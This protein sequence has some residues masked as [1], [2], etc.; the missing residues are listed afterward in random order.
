MTT[1]TAPPPAA[2]PEPA[3]TRV[4]PVTI[5]GMLAVAG[6]FL[7]LGGGAVLAVSGT[8]STLDSGRHA[9]ATPGAA[10]VSDVADIEHTR[11]VESVLGKTTLKASATAEGGKRIFV[12]VGPKA[13]VDRYLAGAPVDTVT[14]LRVDP[15]KLDRTR[16]AGDATPK[17]PARQSFWVAKSS[18]STTAALNWKVRDGSYRLVVMNA[19]GSRRVASDGRLELRLPH[20]STIA[21]ITM[22]AGIG[23]AGGGIAVLVR[24]VGRPR[25]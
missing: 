7:A 22:L 15:F 20:L 24:N 1:V 5:G 17:P 19:D 2:L 3:R 10:L 8:D 11:D 9:L 16:R 6:S 13:A 4:L 18:G 25:A 23:L 14:D 12:G 21:L